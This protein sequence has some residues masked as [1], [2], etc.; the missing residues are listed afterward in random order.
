MDERR[1]A[2]REKREAEEAEKERKERP[3]IQEQFADLKRGLADMTEDDWASLPEVVNL[4]GKRR[5]K[6]ED[7]FAGRS[8]VVPDSVIVGARDANTYEST[9]DEKQMVSMSLL[10][11]L[12][13]PILHHAFANATNPFSLFRTED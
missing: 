5:K 3:P 4:T 12:L 13:F 8:F 9:L 6:M 2:R 11:G 10:A 7:R 1:R